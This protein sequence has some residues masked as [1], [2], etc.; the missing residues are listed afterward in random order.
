MA[1]EQSAYKRT[2]P[3]QSGFVRPK[4]NKPKI[5]PRPG[6]SNIDWGGAAGM[7][8]N[9]DPGRFPEGDLAYHEGMGGYARGTYRRKGWLIGVAQKVRRRA[10]IYHAQLKRCYN[11]LPKKPW[12]HF[13]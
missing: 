5:T 3:K 2:M 11:S 7:F 4:L 1:Y 9:R 12:W 6:G 8:S 10:W 13:W